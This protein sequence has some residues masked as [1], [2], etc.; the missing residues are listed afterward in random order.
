M[1]TAGVLPPDL[2]P[3]LFALAVLAAYC[4]VG[5]LPY[6][7]VSPPLFFTAALGM[8][9]AALR[10]TLPVAVAASLSGVAASLLLALDQIVS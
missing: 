3:V 1:A 2:R 4:V 10:P 5:A 8:A 6:G 7:R 9:A